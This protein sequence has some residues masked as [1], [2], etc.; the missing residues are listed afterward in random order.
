[1]TWRNLWSV[2][3]SWTSWSRTSLTWSTAS[4]GTTRPCPRRRPGWAPR[5]VYVVIGIV[6]DMRRRADS[7]FPVITRCASTTF[8]VPFYLCNCVWREGRS[9]RGAWRRAVAVVPNFQQSG[10]A[11]RPGLR[12]RSLSAWSADRLMP[13]S[14]M[15]WSLFGFAAGSSSRLPAGCSKVR[16]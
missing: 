8:R 1:M 9:C 10:E 14:P 13:W 7:A 5:Y 11:R 4:A 16:M 3:R 12:R 2:C 6:R 15:P